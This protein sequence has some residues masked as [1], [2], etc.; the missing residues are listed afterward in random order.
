M[1]NNTT[2]PAIYT[3]ASKAADEPLAKA[4][5][6]YLLRVDLDWDSIPID[7]PPEARFRL[8]RP[9]PCY[10]NVT[11]THLGFARSTFIGSERN[12]P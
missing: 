2:A 4:A 10:P 12:M 5:S 7:L 11:L 6:G 8:V 1:L 9:V 3:A